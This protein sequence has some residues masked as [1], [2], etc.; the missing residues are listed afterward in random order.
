MTTRP[1]RRWE[2]GD[3]T[4]GVSLWRPTPYHNTNEAVDEEVEKKRRDG[5]GGS[6]KGVGGVE[7]TPTTAMIIKIR[8]M[9]RTGAAVGLLLVP[10]TPPRWPRG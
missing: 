2:N 5:E 4:S 7:L 3:R 6:G 10:T 8:M 9:I 1:T